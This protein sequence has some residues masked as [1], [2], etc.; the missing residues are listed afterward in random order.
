M[1]GIVQYLLSPVLCSAK[2]MYL[3]VTVEAG[4]VVRSLI[5]CSM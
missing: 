1:N 5:V 3:S 4:A 2:N